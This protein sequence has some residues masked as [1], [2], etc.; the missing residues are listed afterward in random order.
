MNPIKFIFILVKNLLNFFQ[1]IIY[2]TK[3]QLLDNYFPLH[4]LYSPHYLSP[5]VEEKACNYLSPSL[6]H[7]P[8]KFFYVRVGGTEST[9]KDITHRGTY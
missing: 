6:L 4:I 3:A 2:Y 9:W 1:P 8:Y 5:Q 7:L